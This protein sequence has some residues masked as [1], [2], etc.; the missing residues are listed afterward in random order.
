MYGAVYY[1]DISI[2]DAV[3]CLSMNTGV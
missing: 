2:S 1:T 3:Q